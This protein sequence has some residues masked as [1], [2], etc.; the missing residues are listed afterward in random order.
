VQPG[1]SNHPNGFL[2][3]F[4]R[5]QRG[6]SAIVFAIVLPVLIG[7]VGIGVEMGQWFHRKRSMQ[8][9]ADAGAMAGALVLYQGG[10]WADAQT[11]A[12]DFAVRNGAVA[13]NVTSNRPPTSGAYT[14]AATYPNAVEVIVT[15]SQNLMFASLFLSSATTLSAR[16]VANAGTQTLGC[17]VALSGTAAPAVSMNSN[18]EMELEGCG[19]NVNSSATSSDA[20][21]ANALQ[22]ASN[23]EISADFARITGGYDLDGNAS[24]G[25]TP[26]TTGQTAVANPYANL[27]NPAASGACTAT[28]YSLGAN[29]TATI[30]PG[31]YCGGFNMNSNSNVTMTAG[32][33]YIDGGTFSMSSNTTLTATAGVTLILTGSGA[34]WAELNINSNATINIVAPNSG[35][36]EGIAIMQD[37]DAPSTATNTLNS[38]VDIQVEGSLYF[39][40]TQ[41][42]MDSNSK[43][44]SRH[45][46]PQKGC[47]LIIANTISM[48]SNA[49]IEIDNDMAICDSR[50]VPTTT[51]NPPTLV[52]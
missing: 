34:D 24:L 14:N 10:T 11:A 18:S 47:A 25:T 12:S 33:Y 35:T 31:R 8:A 27:A 43:I 50:G 28:N 40:N 51:S 30:G 32:T 48:N 38:N 19:L 3:R 45:S 52:E 7:F 29:N 23:A 49:E 13:A 21:N 17:V 4:A 42:Q 6:V 1:R 5:D 39:P 15:E 26:T 20:A 16:A 36:Y 41:L 2:S 46:G 9:A 22:M 37:P 44:R